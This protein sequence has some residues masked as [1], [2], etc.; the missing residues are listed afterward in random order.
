MLNSFWRS[1]VRSDRSQP[2][3][4]L[5]WLQWCSR[6]CNRVFISRFSTLNR[7]NWFRK[8]SR[9]LCL[10]IRDLRADSRFDIIRLRFRSSIM[11]P[12]RFESS[13]AGFSFS[14]WVWLGSSEPVL[15]VTVLGLVGSGNKNSGHSHGVK[16]QSKAKNGFESKGSEAERAESMVAIT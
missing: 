7:F 11:D 4:V 5:T 10:R 16:P 6:N 15:E 3:S 2:F 14:S 12:T 9:C 8:L 1:K 13:E